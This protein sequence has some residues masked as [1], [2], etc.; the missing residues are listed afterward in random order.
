MH[1]NLIFS[2]RSVPYFECLVDYSLILLNVYSISIVWCSI[3]H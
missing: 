3:I 2:I 1:F